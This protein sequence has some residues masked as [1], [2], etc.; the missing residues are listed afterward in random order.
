MRSLMM[1]SCASFQPSEWIIHTSLSGL[2]LGRG[3]PPRMEAPPDV[4]TAQAAGRP[5]TVYHT[6]LPH[7]PHDRDIN[8]TLDVLLSSNVLLDND[9]ELVA[10]ATN[11]PHGLVVNRDGGRVLRA[12]LRL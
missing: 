8:M 9:E 10:L 2:E 3:P 7:K 6:C 11:L 4:N 1:C 12:V 5:K